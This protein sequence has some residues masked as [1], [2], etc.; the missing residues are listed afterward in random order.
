VNGKFVTAIQN[1]QPWM[2]VGKNYDDDWKIL[3]AVAKQKYDCDIIIDYEAYST[4]GSGYP[5]RFN[6]LQFNV[7]GVKYELRSTE[8]PATVVNRL[9]EIGVLDE[10]SEDNKDESE[11]KEAAKEK[12]KEKN[13]DKKEKSKTRVYSL[14]YYA[15]DSYYV[16]SLQ[17]SAPG[18]IPVD[19]D[20]ANSLKGGEPV[21]I[22][23]FHSN[24]N[25]QNLANNIKYFT[26]TTSRTRNTYITLQG[27]DENTGFIG[28]PAFY[29]EA[30]GTYRV[31]GVNIGI[32]DG[33]NRIVP[34]THIP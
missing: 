24:T 12:N 19:K 2:P 4:R 34:I 5:L 29:K 32:W 9:M 26:S 25:I 16:V 15:S 11:G 22:A 7:S 18:N 13:K 33:E 1:I 23:G 10:K 8:V 3:L 31:V 20:V 28:S 14:P 6:N 30:D 21:T 27:R 17:M